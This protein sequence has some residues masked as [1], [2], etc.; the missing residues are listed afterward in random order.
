M[1][2]LANDHVALADEIARLAARMNVATHR[3]LTCIRDFDA[4]EAGIGRGLRAA[5]T[6]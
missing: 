5:R 2:G 3:M 4:A 1:N 6:G